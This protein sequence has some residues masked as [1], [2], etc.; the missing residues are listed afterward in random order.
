ML[1]LPGPDEL[2]VEVRIVLVGFS[3]GVRVGFGRHEA[4]GRIVGPLLLGM[5]ELLYGS[6]FADFPLAVGFLSDLFLD[7]D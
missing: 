2:R 3:A 4:D 7:M 5:L 1:G 6:L